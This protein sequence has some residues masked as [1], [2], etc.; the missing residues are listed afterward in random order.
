MA[1]TKKAQPEAIVSFTVTVEVNMSMGSCTLEEALDKARKLQP[2]DVVDLN[3]LE[4]N[5][6]SIKVTGV[7]SL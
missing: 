1:V 2:T 5:D 7:F 4:Y 3:G 6:G